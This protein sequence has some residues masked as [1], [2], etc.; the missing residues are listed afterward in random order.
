MLSLNLL[1][2][3][4]VMPAFLLALNTLS[5]LL[6][7]VSILLFYVVLCGLISVLWLHQ[8][9]LIDVS[10]GILMLSNACLKTL[11][12]TLCGTVAWMTLK[13]VLITLQLMILELLVLITPGGMVGVPLLLPGSWTELWVMLPGSTTCLPLKFSFYLMG[14]LIIALFCFALI[15]I[16]LTPANLSSS[17]TS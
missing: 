16:F 10:W 5:S 11:G 4:S 15:V 17:L 8:L 9:P 3:F 7:M 12:V 13:L 2:L 1:S 14:Y 6:F